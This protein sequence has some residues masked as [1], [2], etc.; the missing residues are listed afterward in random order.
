V[1]S[2]DGDR[3]VIIA[4]KAGAPTNPDWYHN[5]KANPSVTLEVGE[6]TFPATATIVEGAERDRLFNAQAD[7]MPG[8]RDYEKA[9]DRVI[10]VVVLERA[11]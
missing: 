3:I 9:T 7:A 4:S 2:T 1:Y 10:P 6:E 8:F 11:G 5:I